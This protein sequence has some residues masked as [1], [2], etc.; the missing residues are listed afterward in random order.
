MHTAFNGGTED[1]YHLVY[2]YFGNIP[3]F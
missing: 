3:E 2:E 1:R